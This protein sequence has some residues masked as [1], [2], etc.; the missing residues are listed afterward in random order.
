MEAARCWAAGR[1]R[2]C[3]HGGLPRHSRQLCCRRLHHW[4]EGQRPGQRPNHRQRQRQRRNRCG[5]RWRQHQRGCWHRHRCS[6][7]CHWHS[8]PCWHRHGRWHTHGHHSC[9]R[10]CRRHRH[11]CQCSHGRHSC[12]RPCWHWRSRQRSRRCCRSMRSHWR[13]RLRRRLAAADGQRLPDKLHGRLFPAQQPLLPQR[14]PHS[15]A[16]ELEQRGGRPNARVCSQEM[17][18]QVRK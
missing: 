13:S 1:G 11:G 15:T 7:W 14:G 9:C 4:L 6:C 8:R 3:R 17:G 12:C 5:Q 2:R 16:F 10:T 18:R